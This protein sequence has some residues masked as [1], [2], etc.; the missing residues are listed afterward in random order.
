MNGGFT[1]LQAFITNITNAQQAVITYSAPHTFIVGEI[2]SLRVSTP[3]GMVEANN[4]EVQVLAADSTTTTVNLDST[5]FTPF[6]FV[7]GNLQ[8]P[9]QAV[10]SASGV[11]NNGAFELITIADSFDNVPPDNIPTISQPILQPLGFI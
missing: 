5:F 1:P 4:K 7:A 2:I 8:F 11:I 6:T 9:A 10:P 3:Y